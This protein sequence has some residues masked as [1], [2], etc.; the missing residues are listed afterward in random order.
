MAREVDRLAPIAGATLPDHPAAPGRPQPAAARDG[1]GTGLGGPGCVAATPHPT[2]VPRPAEPAALAAPPPSRSR[3]HGPRR[4]APVVALV[5]ALTAAA[6][7]GGVDAPPALAGLR[8]PGAGGGPDGPD[9]PGVAYRAPVPAPVALV[10]PF[11]APAQPWAAGHRGVDLTLEEGAVVLAPAGGTVT[12]AGRV[13]DRGVV[14][15]THPDGRRSSLEPVVPA[16]VVGQRVAAGDRLGTLSG[17]RS[18]CPSACLHWGVR[19]GARYVDPLTLLP[20]GGP[21][22]LL[23][24]EG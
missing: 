14:T 10:H 3:R 15:V 18:H 13:V 23:P 17:E 6:V 11:V 24:D 20:G 21:V 2:D 8:A 1:H 22:V 9:G 7:A 19:K 12:V 16:V 4:A 5:L